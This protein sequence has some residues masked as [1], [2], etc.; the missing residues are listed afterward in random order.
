M[1]FCFSQWDVCDSALTPSPQTSPCFWRSVCTHSSVQMHFCRL[2]L[3]LP[4]LRW[5][6]KW[7]GKLKDLR[8]K[9]VLTPRSSPTFR[10]ETGA[11]RNSSHSLEPQ[12]KRGLGVGDGEER[13]QVT[14]SPQILLNLNDIRT[15]WRGSHLASEYTVSTREFVWTM[16]GTSKLH[17]NG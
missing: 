15:V 1:N 8:L 12:D 9:T 7:E 2:R 5:S 16:S 6:R 10:L 11:I 4:R 17:R 3:V 13:P 14:P